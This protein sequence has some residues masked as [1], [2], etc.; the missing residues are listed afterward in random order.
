MT[1]RSRTDGR[2]GFRCVVLVKRF[3]GNDDRVGG[4]GQE[5]KRQSGVCVCA[6]CA[7]LGEAKGKE[8]KQ[9]ENYVQTK[10]RTY[11]IKMKRWKRKILNQQI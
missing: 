2:I 3:G 11:K 9:N 8:A 1:N 7:E 10:K 6:R 5:I 4:C